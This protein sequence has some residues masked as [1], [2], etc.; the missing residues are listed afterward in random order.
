MAGGDALDLD[1]GTPRPIRFTIPRLSAL[2]DKQVRDVA[3]MWSGSLWPAGTTPLWS[4]LATRLVRSL[5]GEAVVTKEVAEYTD[6]APDPD[7]Y[8]ADGQ[9]APKS[10]QR[11]APETLKVSTALSI[12][13]TDLAIALECQRAQALVKSLKQSCGEEAPK[14]AKPLALGVADI[15]KPYKPSQ[16]PDGTDT[17]TKALVDAIAEEQPRGNRTFSEY[18]DA[19]L[20]ASGLERDD[21]EERLLNDPLVV[22]EL[23]RKRKIAQRQ[24]LWGDLNGDREKASSDYLLIAST[25]QNK[26]KS[27]CLPPSWQS[28]AVTPTLCATAE[29]DFAK[30][31]RVANYANWP[32]YR[33]AADPNTK[34][35]ATTEPLEG[36]GE[37][38][39]EAVEQARRAFFTMQS[40]PSLA[41]VFMLAVEVEIADTDLGAITTYG[42]ITL[43]MGDD[44][45]GCIP[46]NWTLFRRPPLPEATLQSGFWPVSRGEANCDGLKDQTRHY[47][48]LM[49]M[50]FGAAATPEGHAPRFDISSLDI[51]TALELETQRRQGKQADL[52]EEAEADGNETEAAARMLQREKTIT[53]NLE[54]KA[55]DVL[56][57]RQGAATDRGNRRL[58]PGVTSNLKSDKT[59]VEDQ[60]DEGDRQDVGLTLLDRGLLSDAICKMATKAAKC[61]ALPDC[62]VRCNAGVVI[63]AEDLITGYRLHVGKPDPEG[64]TDWR[65]LMAR[66]IKFG[67]SGPDAGLNTSIEGVLTNLIGRAGSDDRVALESAMMNAPGRMLPR[68]PGRSS[69]QESEAVF[70]E[71]IAIWDGGPMGVDCSEPQGGENTTGDALIF[72]R[73]LSV[74]TKGDLRP[75]RLRYGQPYRF[76][77]AAVLSG[78]HSIPQD[79]FP[80]DM[81][82]GPLSPATDLY[83]PSKTM[84]SNAQD[85]DP[86]CDLRPYVR[87]LRQAKI[88]APQ[89]TMPEGHATRVNGPMGPDHAGTMVIRRLDKKAGK[90]R[91]P[92]VTSR[93]QP[94][95]AQRI[96]MVPSIPQ[97]RA[98]THTNLLS[99]KGVFDQQ[100]VSGPPRGAYRTIRQ[101]R[102]DATLPAV[103]T[104]NLAGLNG[105]QHFAKRHIVDDPRDNL[106]RG[107]VQNGAV[108]ARRGAQNTSYYPDPA[109]DHLAIR[110]LLRGYDRPITMQGEGDLIPLDKADQ[111]PH[112]TPV[113]LSLRHDTSMKDKRTNWGDFVHKHRSVTFDPARRGDITRGGGFSATEIPLY[114]A[115]HEWVDVQMWFVPTARRLARDFSVL[116]TMAID[117]AQ[118]GKGSIASCAANVV[119]GASSHLPDE[120]CDDLEQAI[121]ESKGAR[122]Y[123]GSGGIASPAMNVLLAL[124]GTVRD[125][126][127][128]HPMPEIAATA[129]LCAISA[130][131]RASV[132]PAIT[133]VQPGHFDTEVPEAPCPANGVRAWRPA[134]D[135][136]EKRVK[137]NPTPETDTGD[138]PMDTACICPENTTSLDVAHP[139]STELVLTGEVELDLNQI[140]TIEVRADMVLPG[141]TTFDDKF[142]GRSLSHREADWWPLRGDPRGA[143]AT[144][145]V[146]R[147][148]NEITFLESR[149][150]FGFDVERDGKVTLARAEVTLLRAERLPRPFDG[151]CRNSVSLRPLFEC[152]DPRVRITERHIFPDGKA[153]RM[154]VSINGLA[155]TAEFMRTIDR[156]ARPGDPWIGKDGPAYGVGDLVPAEGLSPLDQENRSATVEAILPATIRPAKPDADALKPGFRWHPAPDQPAEIRKGRLY[157]RRSSIIRIPLG[158]EWFSSGEDEKLGIVLWPPTLIASNTGLAK[159]KALIRRP[160]QEGGNRVVKLD[161]TQLEGCRPEDT[162][163]AAEAL[164]PATDI[165]PFE[166]SHLGPGGRFVSRRGADPVRVGEPHK[167]IFFA[168]SDFPDLEKGA[169]HIGKATLVRNVLMPLSDESQAGQ[170]E[171]ADG[172]PADAEEPLPPMLVSLLTY[173][174]R[175]DAR[176]EEWYVEVELADSP[177][178][179]TFVRLGLVRYQP[180]TRPEL[181]CSRPVE[182]WIQPLPVRE[183]EVW[184][185]EKDD[186]WRVRMCGRTFD[187]RRLSAI[188]ISAINPETSTYPGCAADLDGVV[189]GG[190]A[191]PL[192]SIE[193][194]RRGIDAAG[195]PFVETIPLPVPA[196]GKESLL[197]RPLDYDTSVVKFDHKFVPESGYMLAGRV[198]VECGVVSRGDGVWA[199]VIPDQALGDPDDFNDI[200]IFVEDV[201]RSEVD[202]PM[203]VEERDA[204]PVLSVASITAEPTKAPPTG[205][206][207]EPP[208]E[209]LLA[210][211]FDLGGPRFSGHFAL[212]TLAKQRH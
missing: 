192:M 96:I 5:T 86:E 37:A 200:E 18:V 146:D 26:D 181:R 57:T 144:D 101:L 67:T 203:M 69:T 201:E 82:S 166:D 126:M 3:R 75:H 196:M 117:L 32:Q 106:D 81:K 30:L 74:P 53:A 191:A 89:V 147:D 59:H 180:H 137:A 61:G 13:H 170:R 88:A 193:V 60:S 112:L 197:L 123:F 189:K 35:G 156:R 132:A 84:V 165:P 92:K 76:A 9:L 41:R 162:P 159:N 188:A 190:D 79:A 43:D 97:A 45:A 27:G 17:E 22:A 143:P 150:L 78:G 24:K 71:A 68:H 208:P 163:A 145:T 38:K 99:H 204:M 131:N 36:W 133:A 105:R 19:L 169:D 40:T 155:R 118:K 2:S 1:E 186:G 122:A 142:R 207:T 70:E 10:Q 136:L 110:L 46:Q 121:K 120:I 11:R 187:R 184:R 64:T 94:N 168:P 29:P 158:R 6:T 33:T 160:Y 47:G 39:S 183:V 148:G 4:E 90:G 66:S 58:R 12:G 173:E 50:G 210:A 154:Q 7:V 199:A 102:G 151:S 175:F 198:L 119:E 16:L 135:V 15:L 178:A 62:T 100:K 111:Y 127:I 176:K 129:E 179:E 209:G 115:A 107:E 134:P 44:K 103:R 138:A 72:G 149:A 194:R 85:C 42:H 104:R 128:C 34:P 171:N 73:T 54:N 48:G 56:P 212:A 83:Y 167:Q 87:A 14:L 130:S 113:V 80:D 205:N 31:T 140:D 177:A 51:R 182:Q 124:A 211:S 108:F 174:P 141:T 206:G 157:R 91:K 161:G 63:D 25:L 114:L 164:D 49:V 95:I 125:K 8:G 116:Q 55:N 139:G 52:D 109:A 23:R 185:H 20:E 21:V 98:V 152:R 202:N 153:R 172:S 93:G 65:P 77:M 195:S 28:D